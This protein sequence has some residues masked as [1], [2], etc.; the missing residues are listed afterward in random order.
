[1]LAGVAFLPLLPFL[2]FGGPDSVG[3]GSSVPL[4]GAPDDH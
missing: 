4:V 1:M 3:R 2:P